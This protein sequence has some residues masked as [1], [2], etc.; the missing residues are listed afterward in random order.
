MSLT[1]FRGGKQKTA[2]CV[3]MTVMAK[4]STE[5]ICENAKMAR[6]MALTGN[7]DA[8]GIYY[9][10]LQQMLG[11]LV[12]SVNDPMRKGKWTMIQQ[13]IA[14]EYQQ[15]KSIQKLLTEMTIDL[16]HT[17]LVARLRTPM[18]EEPTKD[19]ASW[20][21]PDPDIWTPPPRD[22]DVF[23]PPL[24]FTKPA[25]PA[26]GTRSGVPPKKVDR[27]S[28]IPQKGAQ[29]T[30]KKIGPPGRGGTGNT[31]NGRAQ[32]TNKDKRASTAPG[33]NNTSANDTS[34]NVNEDQ[35]DE[36]PAEEEKKFEPSSHLEAELVDI[37]ERDILQKNPNIH[38]DDIADLHDAKRLLEEAVVL[39]MWMPDYFKGIRRPWKGVLMVGPPGTGKTM[40]AKAVATECGTTFFNVSS[41]TLTSKYR[42]ESEK[43]VR[44][45][46][47]MA[48]FYAPSTIFIDE[49]DSLC[50]RRGSESEHEASRRV[51]SE[52]LVQM[53]GVGSE[54]A[55]KVVMVLA[56]TN[57]PWDIDEA[58]RRRL[59][60]RIYIPLPTDEGREALL[61]INLREVKVDPSV[62]LK[63]IA[64]K[65]EG[66]SG[67]DIT[68][69][70]RDAS[71]MSM[72][73][74]IA[75]LKPEQIRQL[76]TE[77]VDLPVSTQDFS[78]AI[79]KCNKSVS[80]EDLAKY[81]KWMREF[82]SS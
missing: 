10:G 7:Y 24:D 15:I 53:D 81:E 47:E 45:L 36:E 67:A 78:E 17:P 6:E 30:A 50:S 20:F 52:L 46:F 40:L 9:E 33:G 44:L 51:K 39:P 56:A 59:E 48:R 82:G 43:M 18:H 2:S 72:R 19:P 61:K 28:G 38:W 4:V 75:G 68:N 42:G 49:I 35:K 58:L 77:E 22:P 16:Q 69:V 5:E 34:T 26:R 21:R 76:A 12:S 66:Y 41:S 13:Q 63:S 29:S 73:R 64:K 23:G 55:S 60:K 57:F 25:V 71:M 80:K 14:K 74:K 27:R 32:Q 54:E 1:L 70:C 31:A 62:N 79:A 8:A 37:L 3:G 11:R 65:L